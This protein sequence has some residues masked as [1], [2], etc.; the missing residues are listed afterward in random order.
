MADVFGA[1]FHLDFERALL[2]IEDVDAGATGMQIEPGPFL[3][4]AQGFLAANQV[5]DERGEP[6]YALTLLASAVPVIG[7]SELARSSVVALVPGTNEWQW[8]D[9]VLFTCEDVA[10]LAQVAA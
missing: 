10:I 4:S 9:V 8:G 2:R 3:D 5:D 7:S 6:V 1:E